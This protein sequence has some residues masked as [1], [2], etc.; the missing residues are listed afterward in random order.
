MANMYALYEKR[1]HTKAK[2]L[3]LEFN[4][5]TELINLTTVPNFA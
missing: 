4:S 1:S 5:V 3:L 2:K